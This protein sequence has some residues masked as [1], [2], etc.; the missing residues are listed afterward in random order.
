MKIDEANSRNEKRTTA[1]ELKQQELQGTKKQAHKEYQPVK[2]MILLMEK[3]LKKVKKI[4]EESAEQIK[5]I[6]D[7]IQHKI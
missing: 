1:L 3:E 4:R 2:D 6:R 7:P 5:K